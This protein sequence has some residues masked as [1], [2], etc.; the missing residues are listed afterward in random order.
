MIESSHSGFIVACVKRRPK[1]RL[2]VQIVRQVPDQLA[3]MTQARQLQ[4]LTGL[5][6]LLECLVQL[7]NSSDRS[8]V[9]S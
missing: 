6:S 1:R 5:P 7:K 3:K 9:P 2:C 4:G 8:M